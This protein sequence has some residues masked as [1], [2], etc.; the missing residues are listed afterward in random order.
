MPLHVCRQ[1]LQ[2][3]VALGWKERFSGASTFMVLDMGLH[4]PKPMLP[5]SLHF[6]KTGR[7]NVEHALPPRPVQYYTTTNVF[8]VY[9]RDLRCRSIHFDMLQ[10]KEWASSFFSAPGSVEAMLGRYTRY[11]VSVRVAADWVWP[12][13][14]SGFA[15]HRAHA[16]STAEHRTMPRERNIEELH[17]KRFFHVSQPRTCWLCWV[18]ETVG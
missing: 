2:L 5:R 15:T 12:V 17:R 14:N 6:V 7:L 4:T 11:I 8:H 13:K 9:T 16:M 10:E 18:S 3:R 1:L